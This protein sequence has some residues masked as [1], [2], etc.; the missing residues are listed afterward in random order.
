MRFTI[1]I[2]LLF[3]IGVKAQSFAIID[4]LSK[5]LSTIKD[6]I[7]K[8]ECLSKLAHEYINIDRRKAE[9]YAL[10]AAKLAQDCKNKN[11]EIDALYEL[12]ALDRNEGKFSKALIKL[13]NA[14]H[15]AES[16]HDISNEAKCYLG[17][18]DVYSVLQHYD[19]AIP[20]YEKSFQ[21]SWQIHN[22]ENAIVSLNRQGNRNMDKGGALNDSAYFLK[23]ISI[24]QR[25]QHISD[26]IKNIQLYINSCESLADAYMIFG[27]QAKNNNH[28]YKSMDYGQ[29]ALKLAT[30]NKHPNYIG[31]SYLNLG[32]ACLALNNISRAI[33]YFESAEKEYNAIGDKSWILNTHALLGKTYYA[34]GDYTHAAE[35]IKAAIELSRE[36]KLTQYLSNNYKL[37]A[38]IYSNEKKYEE[39]YAYHKLYSQFRD[40]MINENSA[41]YISRLQTELDMERKDKEIEL[42]TKNTEIQNQKLTNQT[43]QRNI[44]MIAIAAMLCI[45]AFIYYRYQEKQRLNKEILKAKE[46]AEQSKEAQEQFL[47]NTSH[48]IRTPMNG[49]IGM[50]SHLMDTNLDSRQREYVNAIKESSNNLLTLINELLDMSKIIARKIVFDKK[51]FNLR[52]IIR[53]MVQLLDFKAREKNIILEYTIDPAI[54]KTLVGDAIRL[55]QILLNLSENAVKFTN[56]GSV[57]IDVTLLSETEHL[58]NLEF[59]VTDSGIGIPKNK[60]DAV[61][62]HFTQVNA[63]TTRKYGGTGLGLSI[64]KQ[65][66]EQQGGH[67]SVNSELNVGSVF[68]VNLG[69]KKP[70]PKKESDPEPKVHVSNVVKGDLKQARILVVD[71]NKINQQVALLTLQKWN[72]SVEL[73]D[74]AM[75]AYNLLKA[76][77]FDLILM[78]VTMPEI[79]GFEA[80]Q[81]IRQ[82]M[83]EPLCHIPIIANTAAAFIGDR[84]KCLAAGMN[85]Y[86]SKPFDPKDLLKKIETLLGEPRPVAMKKRLSNLNMLRER[87]DGDIQFLKEMLECYI[88]EMPVYLEEMNAFFESKNWMEVS[89][90]AHKMKSPIAL[91]GAESVRALYAEIELT[92]KTNPEEETLHKMIRHAQDHCM[93][94]VVEL[95]E[96][97]KKLL[98]NS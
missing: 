29:L 76:Q 46:L 54:P 47:A 3:S 37:L 55:N 69:F 59:K 7:L 91:M 36:Q 5:S 19:K 15:I 77:P 82:F 4:S 72:A 52:D 17:I 83:P 27:K 70:Q 12:A 8:S 48:E 21:L 13:K 66:V 57:R 75:Q 56:K 67:I 58:V 44:L 98:H 89:K 40:S 51:P 88:V 96:E 60:L 2:V 97:L 68:T 93:R 78:D 20:N 84:E 14:L 6:P 26:S 95:D 18:G 85:D 33:G 25:S 81:Y 9:R 42:L 35:H 38:D 73:A 87:A 62:D 80:T 22:F 63:K 30:K 34:A 28:L 50:T 86:I 94:T 92:A 41:M 10:Q 74:S 11:A 24:Y 64:C 61:F 49:I 45:L 1:V 79:D 71:D 39:A 23:A 90:Q 16:G 65:L 32:E 43:I 53:H 31:L